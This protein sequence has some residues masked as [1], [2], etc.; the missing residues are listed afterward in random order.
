MNDDRTT[1]AVEKRLSCTQVTELLKEWSAGDQA[2]LEK[3]TP[4][5]Y[6]ELRQSRIVTW[7]V[8]ARTIPCKPLR[9]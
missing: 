9:W 1:A 2:A 5:V 6:D 4:L 8:R 3:L 7:A